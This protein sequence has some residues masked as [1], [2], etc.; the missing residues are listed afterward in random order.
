M[1]WY[2]MNGMAVHIKMR[3]APAPCCVPIELD[4]TVRWVWLRRR[5]RRAQAVSWAFAAATGHF[6]SDQPAGGAARLSIA[7]LERAWSALAEQDR[8]WADRLVSEP[9]VRECCYEDWSARP[10]SLANDVLAW[11]GH[12]GVAGDVVLVRED[13]DLK[14]ALVAAWRQAD[15][16]AAIPSA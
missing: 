15:E 14:Q 4:G 10:R 7:D 16:H 2:R 6:H 3:N 8:L 5:D 13:E 9:L 12:P 11:A 1:P